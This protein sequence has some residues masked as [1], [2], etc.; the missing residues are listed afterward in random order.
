MTSTRIIAPSPARAKGY[1]W[2]EKGFFRKAQYTVATINSVMRPSGAFQSTVLD[3]AKWDAALY[4]DDVLTDA[5][6]AAMWTPVR[7]TD[8][9]PYRYGF[10]W[11][12]DV[13]DGHRRVSHGGNVNGFTSHIVRFVDDSLTVIV[14]SNKDGEILDGIGDQVAYAFVPALRPK[15]WP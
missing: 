3:L 10:G 1:I 2:H 4:R 9:T 14:L 11:Y 13:V 5:S 7:L 8:G 15:P 12:V 6:R